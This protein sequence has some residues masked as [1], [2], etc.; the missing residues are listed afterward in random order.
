MDNSYDFNKIIET[1]RLFLWI[2]TIKL[3]TISR[4]LVT[5]AY[6]KRIF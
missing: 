2:I 3:I 5:F 4:F 1:I 6:N